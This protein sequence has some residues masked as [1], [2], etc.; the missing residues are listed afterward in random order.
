MLTVTLQF[1]T[2]EQLVEFFSKP[3]IIPNKASEPVAAR[4]VQP[5]DPSGAVNTATAR[6]AS[7][8]APTGKPRGRPKKIES[9]AGGPSAPPAGATPP[10]PKAAPAADPKPVAPAAAVASDLDAVR[11][12][13]QAVVEKLGNER[14]MAE[15]RRVLV[16][17]AGVKVIRDVPA[18]RAG[19]V[20]EGLKALLA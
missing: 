16:E 20:V 1:Q 17:K 10:A 14:G 3:Q 15:A 11:K 6:L 13:A 9:A 4:A 18:D 8:A 19:A 2:T 5:L 7:A 12:T